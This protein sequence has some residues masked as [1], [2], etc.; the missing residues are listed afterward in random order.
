MKLVGRDRFHK[1]ERSLQ[2]DKRN[3]ILTKHWKTVRHYW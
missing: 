3:S 2:E 1:C